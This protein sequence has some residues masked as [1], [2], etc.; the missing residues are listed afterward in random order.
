MNQVLYFHK[1]SISKKLTP[2]LFDKYLV[3]TPKSFA[4]VTVFLWDYLFVKNVNYDFCTSLYYCL[5]FIIVLFCISPKFAVKA[6]L[7]KRRGRHIEL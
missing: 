3:S 6:L 5:I 1:L 2:Q 7:T 4:V